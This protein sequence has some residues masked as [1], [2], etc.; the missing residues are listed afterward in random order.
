M[1]REGYGRGEE[2]IKE[3]KERRRKKNDEKGM[4]KRERERKEWEGRKM[5][6]RRE[7]VRE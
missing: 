3:I 4:K 7:G 1:G 2:G 6:K 5:V